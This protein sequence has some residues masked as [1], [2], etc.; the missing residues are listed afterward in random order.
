MSLT[1]EKKCDVTILLPCHNEEMALPT[2][3]KS[4]FQV[5]ENVSY[6]YELVVVDD[7]STDRSAFIAE[8]LGCRVLRRSVQAGAGAARKTGIAAAYGEIIVMLD[9]DGSYSPV[10]IPK[11]LDFFP[12]YDQVNGARTREK[13]S[14]YLLRYPAKWVIRKI[15]SCLAGHKIPDLNTGLKAFKRETMLQYVWTIPDGFSCV[16]S[17]TL[18]FLCNGHAVKYIPTEY[19]KRIGKSKFHP[20]KDTY[21]YIITVLRLITYFNPLRVYLPVAMILLFGGVIK[22]LYDFFFVL[23]RLQMADIIIIITGVIVALQGLL[24]DLIVAQTRRNA[25]QNYY[26][27]SKSA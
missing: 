27:R 11:M 10:D 26:E 23:G 7:K 19:H 2:V 21:L 17:M 25:S 18:A 1:K 3:I 5:M 12:E 9:A 13:G 22:S 8:N 14:Y 15:A 20:I 4:I 24:A 6:S 16:S